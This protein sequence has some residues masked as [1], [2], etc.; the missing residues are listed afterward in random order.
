MEKE[1]PKT[2]YQIEKIYEALN[3]LRIEQTNLSQNLQKKFEVIMNKLMKIREFNQI[4]DMT[5][6]VFEMRLSNIEDMLF[7]ITSL[8]L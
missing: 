8:K 1:S 6:Q 5:N 4:E 3:E 7:K 2:D